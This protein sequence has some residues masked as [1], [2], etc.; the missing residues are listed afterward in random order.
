VFLTVRVR[1]RAHSL[2]CGEG[3]TVEEILEAD[4][5]RIRTDINI[6]FALRGNRW[7]SSNLANKGIR[8]CAE[9]FNGGGLR[10]SGFYIGGFL[11]LLSV[12]RE[13]NI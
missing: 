7:Y 2:Q 8:C 1:Y 12:T 13:R 6:N 4:D 5:K 3:N 9:P 10:C 11:A